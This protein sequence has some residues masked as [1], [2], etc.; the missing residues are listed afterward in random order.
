MPPTEQSSTNSVLIEYGVLFPLREVG[1]P[2]HVTQV[3]IG[4]I[5]HQPGLVLREK[6]PIFRGGQDRL[7]LLPEVFPAIFQLIIEPPVRNRRHPVRSTLPVSGQK[8]RLFRICQLSQIGQAD[9]YRMKGVNRNGAIRIR[10]GTGMRRRRV[11]HRKHL[12]DTLTRFLAQSTNIR[13]SP[14]SPTPKLFSER[15]EKTGITEPAHRHKG[16]LSRK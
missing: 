3:A 14:R 12:D 8:G 5:R 11:V 15:K 1:S 9:I 13:K 10:I 6:L 2:V 16:R 4:G 7:A